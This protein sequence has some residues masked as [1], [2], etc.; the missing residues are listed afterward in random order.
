MPST[1][2]RHT[3]LTVGLVLALVGSSGCL[4]AGPLLGGGCEYGRVTATPYPDVPATLTN[5][6]VSEFAEGFERARLLERH[7]GDGRNLTYR[8]IADSVNRTGDGWLVHLTGGF[9]EKGCHG[10][11]SYVADGVVGAQYFVNETAV[12]RAD[13]YWNSSVDPRENGTKVVE[14]PRSDRT[15]VNK[16]T[17]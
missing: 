12:Y 17:A 6:T 16:V 2:S 14:N 10:T 4:G 5:E 15:S 7:A 1:Q 13:A 8:I 9:V 11:G 3:L